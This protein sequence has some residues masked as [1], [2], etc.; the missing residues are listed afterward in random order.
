M[1]QWE[2]AKWYLHK[3]IKVLE[4]IAA[5]TESQYRFIHKREMK[6][7]GRVLGE[8]EVLLEELL[9]LNQALVR[10]GNWQHVSELASVILD[11]TKKQQELLERSRQVLQEAM[12]ERTRIATELK[13][14]KIHRSV[15]SQYV[16]PWTMMMW[17]NHINERG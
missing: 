14:G 9:T 6:G 16:N 10:E 15:R 7:L 1:G 17:G 13:N 5:N 3:K 2:K 11:I 12:I 8:R 4:K